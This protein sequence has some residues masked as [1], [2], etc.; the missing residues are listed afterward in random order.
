MEGNRGPCG[1]GQGSLKESIGSVSSSIKH[2][3]SHKGARKPWGGR[4]VIDPTNTNVD[5][6]KAIPAA[7]AQANG[8]GCG[9]GGEKATKVQR[10]VG[11]R[12]RPR[13]QGA[14]S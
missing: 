14:D 8:S 11:M 13:T 3:S 4:K 12:P 7:G 10:Y 5:S 1:G 6:A 9:A 2:H